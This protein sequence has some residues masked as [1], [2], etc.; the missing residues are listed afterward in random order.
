MARPAIDDD[1]Y[2]RLGVAPTATT[3]EIGAA[4]R[5]RAK[6]MH[7]DLHPGDAAAGERF[8]DLTRAYD[9]LGRPDVRADYDRRRAEAARSAPAPRPAAVPGHQPV[10]RTLRGARTA[11]WSGVAL[12]AVGVVAAVVLGS[13]ETGDAAKAITLW[14][15]AV[16][17]VVCGLILGGIG[18]WRAHRLGLG[19]AAARPSFATQR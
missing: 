19:D 11:L 1:L 14:L 17:L 3:E 5:A 9:I 7:P 12:V 4:F 16:K 2:G 8:K 10:F 13:V 6:T 15:V 18:A